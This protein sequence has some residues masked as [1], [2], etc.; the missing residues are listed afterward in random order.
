MAGEFQL[1]IS[2]DWRD[3]QL[4]DSG[5]RRKLERFGEV[6]VNRPDPQALWS[7]QNPVESWKADAVF[8]SK[9]DEDERGAWS[10]SGK[11]PP[12]DWAITWEGLKLNA[13]LAA[14]RHMGVFPEHSVHWRW[15]MDQ[16]KTA[17]R[18]VRALNLFGYTG[19]MSLALAKTGAEV[20]HLDAS[21]KTIAQ[22]RENQELSGLSSK[23]IRWICDDAMKFMEREV[24]RERQ[25]EAIVLDPPKFGRGPKNETWR[26]EED[27][28]RL[29]QLVKQLMSDKPLFVI[30]TVYAVRLSYIAV[31]Q[32][33]AGAMGG[34]KVVNGEMAI[35]ESGARNLILPTG[36]FA[37]WTP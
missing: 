17:Q 6:R 13:R 26:F 33:L 29:L 12:D 11:P 31:G 1:L 10:F 30:A 22:G 8:A 36:L 9:D 4:L 27:F 18:P 25:Y 2:D 19:M 37:R 28:P 7:P 5:G 35:Q 21:P 34:G 20:V 24:R 23:P 14:F 15:A 3:Y 32:S 16:V